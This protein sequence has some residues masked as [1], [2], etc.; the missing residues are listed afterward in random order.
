MIVIIGCACEADA[1]R[2]MDV[3]P[4]RF[5]RFR[6]TMHPEKTALMACKR[7]PSRTQSAGGTGTCRLARIDPLLGQNTPGIRGHHA[8][9]SRET[10]AAVYA[11][12]LDMV[13]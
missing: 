10:P 7:P 3:L 2:M 5:T 4:Q 13:S 6:L 8:E 1:R 11:R 12:A 9:D